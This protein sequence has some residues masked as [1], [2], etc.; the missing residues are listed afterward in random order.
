MYYRPDDMGE[1]Q[2][3]VFELKDGELFTREQARMVWRDRVAERLI[4]EL[5]RRGERW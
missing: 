4:C 5:G 1:I 3:V 2:P